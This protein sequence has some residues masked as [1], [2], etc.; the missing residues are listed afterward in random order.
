MSSL[1]ARLQQR[2]SFLTSASSS[3]NKSIDTSLPSNAASISGGKYIASETRSSPQ[4]QQQ[5]QQQRISSYSPTSLSYAP[6]SPS[7]SPTSPSYSPN[8][9]LYSR[10]VFVESSPLI[11]DDPT[12]AYVPQPRPFSVSTTTSSVPLPPMFGAL[13]S[14]R[15]SAL[16]SSSL[17]PGVSIPFARPASAITREGNLA[18]SVF[19]GF[20]GL[21]P[22]TTAASVPP[23]APPPPPP[24]QSSLFSFS[25]APPPPPPLPAQLQQS[26]LF[27]FGSAPPPPPNLFGSSGGSSSG[28]SIFGM[29]PQQPAYGAQQFLTSSTIQP[30]PAPPLAA[31]AFSF[32]GTSFPSQEHSF[33]FGT[34]STTTSSTTNLFMPPP[35]MPSAA[36]PFG[37]STGTVTSGSVPASS[38]FTGFGGFSPSTNAAFMPPPPPQ[39]TTAAFMPPPPP[40]NFFGSSGISN[41]NVLITHAQQPV[42]EAQQ[43]STTSTVPPPP[44]PPLPAFSFGT[45]S[46]DR[47]TSIAPQ[48]S[49][50]PT[51]SMKYAYA[52]TKGLRES[53]ESN[54]TVKDKE[55]VERQKDSGSRDGR[56]GF[57]SAKQESQQRR[58][59]F[60]VGERSDGNRYQSQ[61]QSM[62]YTDV[63]KHIII[64]R[65][66]T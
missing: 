22:S 65:L 63:C 31:A 2:R 12:S 1:K 3:S 13:P 41:N 46:T 45:T 50:V 48:A 49:I 51:S 27:S 53:K 29:H 17:L 5:Q 10:G 20:G 38:V 28:S 19:T 34:T 26:S 42:Y 25:A 52:A 15:T 18:S 6:T 61:I 37:Q 58:E 54:V 23:P 14:F 59:V 4:F 35:V 64:L 33:T 9:A 55:R 43:M 40:P 30:P 7:Y 57:S 11:R 47:P 39:P 21:S 60:K 24:P 44:P 36:I 62:R 16:T 32:N 66:N 56:R 8:S